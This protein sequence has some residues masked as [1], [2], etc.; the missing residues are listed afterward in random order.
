M[1]ARSPLV[2]GADGLPQQL[3]SA[4]GITVYTVAAAIGATLPVPPGGTGAQAW[5]TTTKMLMAWT[6]VV[7]FPATALQTAAATM[8]NA[9][10]DG[11]SVDC[12]T[13]ADVDAA[14]TGD[15]GAVTGSPIGVIDLGTVP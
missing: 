7:W 13:V 14:L 1:T 8:A 5:S 11:L 10:V 2:I 3:Q 4:D 6:G 9:I 12:G 15:W